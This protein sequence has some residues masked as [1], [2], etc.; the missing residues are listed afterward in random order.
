MKWR[1]SEIY[2]LSDGIRNRNENENNGINNG[3]K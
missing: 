2:S 1:E 3:E